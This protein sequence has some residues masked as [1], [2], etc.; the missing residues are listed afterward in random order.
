MRAVLA[1]LL[2]AAVFWPDQ[3]P[4]QSGRVA[5]DPPILE[6]LRVSSCSGN[7]GAV[8]ADAFCRREGFARAIE[9]R[10]LTEKRRG[11]DPISLSVDA[12]TRAYRRIVCA[13]GGGQG[14]A[15][16]GGTRPPGGARPPE[17]APRPTRFQP[18]VIEGLPVAFCRGECGQRAADAFCR[19]QGFRRAVKFDRTDHKRS[20]IDPL[21]LERNPSTRV[22]YWIDCVRG[23]GHG[24]GQ[25][26][27]QGGGHG[28]GHGG[29]ARRTFERP[30]LEGLPVALC[31]PG[32]RRCGRPQADAFCQR[33]NFR[34]AVDVRE[35]QAERQYRISARTLERMG[36]GRAFHSITC[37]R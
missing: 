16:G 32:R 19:R 33:V 6:G 2:C 28:S 11:I 1:V 13:R 23:G 3:A 12:S 34:A 21:T 26:G 24:A 25:G 7:C 20:G 27:G 31:E 35:T 29:D 37:R 4:A 30:H 8:R 22:F 5:F 17:G 18:P 15:A 10:E 36:A 9:H 14:G